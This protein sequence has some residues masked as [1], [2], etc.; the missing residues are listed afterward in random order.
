MPASQEFEGDSESAHSTMTDDERMQREY[1]IEDHRR[2]SCGGIMMGC[3]EGKSGHPKRTLRDGFGFQRD[4]SPACFST[5]HTL[6]GLTATT[7]AS[8]IMNV[9]RR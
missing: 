7:S 3:I 4:S 1:L 5:R 6:A 2:S 9:S 8:N